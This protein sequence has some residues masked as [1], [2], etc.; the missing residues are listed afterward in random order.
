MPTQ[1]EDLQAGMGEFDSPLF[2]E[3]T[4]GF[5]FDFKFRRGCLRYQ[6]LS[7]VNQM[8]MVR[9]AIGDRRPGYYLVPPS[10]SPIPARGVFEYELAVT[11]GAIIWGIQT[12]T[13]KN[14]NVFLAAPKTTMRIVDLAT[15]AEMMLEQ[16]A[17]AYYAAPLI[18]PS[19]FIVAPP[20]NVM[21]EL[22]SKDPASQSVQVMLLTSEPAISCNT[23]VP[24]SA[25]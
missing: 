14:S 16:I 25:R 2:T 12:I 23:L 22:G 20:G 21:V 15:G 8:R 13:P 4:D 9:N 3:V 11:P 1:T 6:T 10:P 18:L 7:L 17:T 24:P 5:T 19:L